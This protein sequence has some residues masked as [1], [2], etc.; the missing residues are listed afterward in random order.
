MDLVVLQKYTLAVRRDAFRD[1]QEVVGLTGDGAGRGVTNAMMGA[2]PGQ[3]EP[4]ENQQELQP[5]AC[6]EDTQPKGY[7][8]K[9]F[10]DKTQNFTLSCS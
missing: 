3:L 8:G 7:V 2:G 1:C 10:A 6:R 9:R 5:T 4:A